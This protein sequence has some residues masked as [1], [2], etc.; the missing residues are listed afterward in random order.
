GRGV[1][2]AEVLLLPGK[3]DQAIW[4]YFASIAFPPGLDSS[5]MYRHGPDPPTGPQAPSQ[6]RRQAPPQAP[7]L[8]QQGVSPLRHGEPPASGGTSR[9]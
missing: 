8:R 9:S 1:E 7:A 6:A 3:E 5:L 2:H 4:E